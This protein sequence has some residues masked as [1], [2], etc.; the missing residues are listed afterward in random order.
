MSGHFKNILCVLSDTHDQDEVIEQAI[1]IAKSHQAKLTVLLAL[2]SLP[3]TASMVME[4]FTYLESE[5]NIG[6]AA[7]SWLSDK[8]NNWSGDYP[9][10]G[11]VSFGHP[12]IKIISKVV[13][14]SHDLVIKLSDSDFPPDR[15]G[16][17]D[18]RLFRKCPCP[19]WVVRHGQNRKYQSV[20]AALDLNYHYPAH[21]ISVRKKLNMDIL[22]HATHIA[23]LEFAQLKVVHV[24]DSV[25]QHILREGFISVDEDALDSD[26]TAI[27]QERENELESLFS[28]LEKELEP[29]VMDYLKP[30][31][32]IVHGYPRREIAATAASLGA[33][34]VV[35]GTV[36]RLGV[37]GFIMGGTA[38]ETIQQLHCA[39][40]GIKPE[41][42]ETPVEIE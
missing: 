4:S 13:K 30:Q 38:E 36:A 24:F 42:F 8:L 11:K 23:L 1:H 41:G 16:S 18:M 2:E 31:R 15:L 14:E 20:V 29:E 28:E 10:A 6:S 34:V 7:E 39:V 35:L 3:P 17:E 33:D 40:V 12:F 37:P 9:I 21:E 25:P 22:R 26:L 5:R 27:H 19:V 32:V